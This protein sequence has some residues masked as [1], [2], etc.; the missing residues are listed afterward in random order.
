MPKVMLVA[1]AVALS[2]L[3][4]ALAAAQQG[5]PPTGP[6][7]QPGPFGFPGPKLL[8]VVLKL[9]AEQSAALHRIYNDYH[10]K[11]QKAQQEAA[12]EA[13]KNKTTGDHQAH[14]APARADTKSLRDDMINEIKMILT[15]EQRKSFDELLA[16]MGKK[17]KKA[18]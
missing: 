5:K 3:V 12:R 10:K 14:P 8:S 1:G 2:F 6:Q 18:A 9:S 4:A 13:Q 11:E 17:K 15:E 7:E 16:D